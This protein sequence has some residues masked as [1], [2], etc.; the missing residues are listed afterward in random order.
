MRLT[1]FIGQSDEREYQP[2]QL[3]ELQA[4]DITAGKMNNYSTLTGTGCCQF[5]AYCTW[6]LEE[7]SRAELI[8]G[9]I[10]SRRTYTC[11]HTHTSVGSDSY[12]QV[13]LVPALHGSNPVRHAGCS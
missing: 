6:G 11:A 4:K 1:C 10:V 2:N 12:V 13:T 9:S 7:S 5:V 3:T 8:R